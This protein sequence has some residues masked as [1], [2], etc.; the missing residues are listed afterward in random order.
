MRVLNALPEAAMYR[1]LIADDHPLFRAALTAAVADAVPEAI[2]EA[3]ASLIE[4]LA[5]LEAQ[6]DCDLVLLDL[7]MPGSSGFSSLI[8]LRGLRPD[9]PVAIVSGEENPLVIRRAIDFG[10]CGYIPKSASLAVI[11]EAV[12]AMLDGNEWLPE[13]LADGVDQDAAE[14]ALTRQIATLTPQQFK[15]LMA[16]A[17]GRLN[18]QI[19]YEL[20]ITEATVKAHVTAVLRKLGLYR[21]TQAALLARRL[22]DAS[23]GS[24]TPPMD[25]LQSD[26]ADED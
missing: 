8:Q 24:L 11:G 19:G 9:L 15:V 10:A 7:R 18:K 16:L 1:L 23:A 4:L 20:S 21:R 2:V 6:P 25:E 26:V 3:T 12:R 14:Q 22:L 5:K 13:G 17:D